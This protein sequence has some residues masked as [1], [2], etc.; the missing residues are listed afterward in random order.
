MTMTFKRCLITLLGL[1]AV[2]S[3]HASGQ[4]SEQQKPFLGPIQTVVN[5]GF[6]AGLTKWTKTGSSTL[7]LTTT[8]AA[9]VGFGRSSGAW[10]ATAAAETLTSSAVAVPT[11]LTSGSSMCY[12]SVWYKGGDS[13]LTLQVWDG[14]AVLGSVALT[15]AA[16][17]TQTYPVRFVCPTSGTMALRVSAGANAAVVYLDNAFV[18]MAGAPAMVSQVGE[19][20]T[21]T[22]TGSWVANT[23][24]AGRYR[25][26]GDSAQIQVQVATSGAPTA[27]DLTVNNPTGLTTDTTKLP[28]T[29]A[30]T[31]LGSAALKDSVALY[32]SAAVGYVSTTTVNVVNSESTGNIGVVSNAAPFTFGAGDFVHLN[33]TIPIAEWAGGTALGDNQVEYAFN[34]STATTG[35]DTALFGYGPGGAQMYAI[36]A[37]GVRRVQFQTPIQSTDTLIL[38]YQ[39]SGAGNPWLPVVAADTGA[40]IGSYMVQNVVSYGM[41]LGRVS[42]STTQVD[43][44]FGTYAWNNSTYGA[45]GIGWPTNNR[46]RVKKF[47]GGQPV[48]F[49]LATSTAPGLA[50]A[51]VFAAG[52][53]GAVTLQEQSAT[54]ANPTSGSEGR[55]YVKGDK[56]I[57]QFNDAGTVRYKYLDMTGTGVTWVHTTTAP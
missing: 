36:T 53:S 45:V 26:V 28:A 8:P 50:P 5:P 9:N 6:E 17:W 14:S 51:G 37:A 10:D 43:V 39:P 19:W 27:S 1:L 21:F 16:A 20:I 11:G 7:V 32:Y 35:N 25:R 52:V 34:T 22:P 33:Y 12:A 2:F 18:G 49:G 57:F 31:V 38:E 47:S 40:D 3:P 55:V 48:A 23:T 41:R 24:Y 4:F 30:T 44:A 42:G 29:T 56:L 15:T 54:P 13:N 46:W